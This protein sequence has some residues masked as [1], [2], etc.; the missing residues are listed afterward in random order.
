M[1]TLE[2]KVV[3][4]TGA[5]S[6]IGRATV[7]RLAH[8]GASVLAAFPEYPAAS[9][10]V[11]SVREEMG[12][13]AEAQHVLQK[14]TVISPN[15]SVR[16]RMVGDVAVRNDDLDA[17]ERAY[18]KVLERH[19]GSSLRVLD[20]YTN[21]TRV[22]LDKGH[23]EGAKKVTQDLRR[24]W[25]G[26]KQGELAALIMDNLCCE[27]EGEP[28]KAKQ[29]LAKALE[30]RSSLGDSDQTEFSQKIAVDL[31]HACLASGDEKM[32][33]EILSKVAA[34]NHE[35]RSMIAQIQGVFSKTGHE[36]AGQSM[37]AQVG[38]E[39]VELN[40]RGVLAARSGNIEASVQMLIEAVERVPNLQFLVNA[41]KAIFTML[42]R[43]GWDE[44]MG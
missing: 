16:Q 38:K 26:N 39:I 28:A 31:A 25:R 42:D 15:T 2:G 23:T 9:A 18:G 20:D 10:F 17:A 4:V 36:E 14:A 37:L 44:E 7:Q 21:L 41:T 34:E 33:Q 27:Q 12:K 29:A 24:D 5:G 19:Q 30:R 11:A 43:K 6:G 40:N 3:I 13:P 35:D 32:A 8:E 22:M 1:G